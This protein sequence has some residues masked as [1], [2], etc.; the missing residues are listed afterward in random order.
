MSV[1]AGS[2]DDDESSI[3]QPEFVTKQTFLTGS[4][5]TKSSTTSFDFL[6]VLALDQ[7]NDSVAGMEDD[8]DYYKAAKENHTH[9]V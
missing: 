8:D 2:G 6:S 5:F 3:L 1:E 4:G 9:Q 7:S